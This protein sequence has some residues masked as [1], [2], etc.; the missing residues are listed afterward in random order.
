MIFKRRG[1]KIDTGWYSRSLLYILLIKLIFFCSLGIA[2]AEEDK[3]ETEET[4]AKDGALDFSVSVMGDF[5]ANIKGGVRKSGTYMGMVD[6][7]AWFDTGKAGLWKGGQF[8]LHGLNTHGGLATQDLI[9]DIQVCSNIEAGDYT[10]LFEYYFKQQLGSFSFLVGQHDLNSEFVV[11]ENGGNFINSSF[12]IPASIS[13]NFPAPIFPMAS[14]AIVTAWSPSPDFTLVAGVYDGDPGD[15]KSNEYGIN[16]KI[17]IKNEGY[18]SIGEAQYHF[19]DT[20][21]NV[22]GSYKVGAYYHSA[23]CIDLTKTDVEIAG[24]SGFFFVMDQ[25]LITNGPSKQDGLKMFSQIGWG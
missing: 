10:G 11:V 25:N 17:D 9:G 1:L 13:L 3:N 19:I 22:T 20:D 12:G 5:A 18:L 2:R 8:F 23:T 24:K 6:L 4:N 16:N 14:M 21:G 15:F 7:F